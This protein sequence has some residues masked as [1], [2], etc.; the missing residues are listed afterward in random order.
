MLLLS[1]IRVQEEDKSLPQV[2]LLA[3]AESNGTS[4]I[5]QAMGERSSEGGS[6]VSLVSLLLDDMKIA[7]L[8]VFVGVGG[9]LS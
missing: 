4:T 3:Q 5:V 1:Y 7:L 2:H 6:K 9:N 8:T